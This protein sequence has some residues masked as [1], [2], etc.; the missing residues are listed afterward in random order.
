ML[1]GEK[2]T[3]STIFNK[4]YQFEDGNVLIDQVKYVPLIAEGIRLTDKRTNKVIYFWSMNSDRLM[5][6]LRNFKFR[7]R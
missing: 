1:D 4:E 5:K 2:L 7:T 6:K 3:I